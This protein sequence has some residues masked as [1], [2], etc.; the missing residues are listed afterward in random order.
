MLPDHDKTY[1]AGFRLGVTTDTQDSSGTVLSESD[2]AVTLTE[3]TE[4]VNKFKGDI[5]QIPPMYS[6]VSVG[7]KRLYEL[8]REG[9]TVERSPR[10]ITVYSLE[11]KS[12]DVDKREGSMEIS[13]SKGTYIRT[14]I[15]DIGETSGCGGIMTSLLR[16]KACGFD[17]SQCVTLEQLQKAADNGES[18]DRFITP[19]EKVFGYLPKIRLSDKQ[20]KMYSNGVRLDVNRLDI[21]DL[22]APRHAVYGKNGFMGTAVVMSDQMSQDVRFS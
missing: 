9:K 15:N 16:T 1:L 3:L 14:L 18:F 6:A 10:P 11:I 7:G 20:E 22:S 8:A 21:E 12:Y 13:C 19:I 4:A 5:M 2:K 17:I